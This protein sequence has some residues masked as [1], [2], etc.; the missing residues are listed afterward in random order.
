MV[1]EIY[2][3]GD[4]N[5]LAAIMNAIAAL[6]GNGTY[7]S[8]MSLSVL[9]GVLIIAFQAVNNGGGRFDIQVFVLSIVLYQVI[10]LPKA[11]VM[12]YDTYTG[13]ARQVDNVPFG[14]AWI[15]STLNTVSYGI[16]RRMELAFSTPQMTTNGFAG[17]LST[18]LNAQRIDG[19]GIADYGCTASPA[20]TTNYVALNQQDRSCSISQSVSNYIGDCVV[21]AI[22]RGDRT[23]ADIYRAERV[24]DALR[25]DY[26]ERKTTLRI[27]G[28]QPMPPSGWEYTCKDAYDILKGRLETSQFNNSFNEFLKGRFGEQDPTAAL[29][30]AMTALSNAAYNAQDFALN[31]ALRD[32]VANGM[33][34][35]ANQ[36]DAMMAAAM[37]GPGAAQRNVQWSAEATLFSKLIRPLITFFEGMMYATAPFVAFLLGL[38]TFGLKVALKYLYLPIWVSLWMP[39]MAICNLY[40]NMIAQGRMAAFEV[41]AAGSYTSMA[42]SVVM[43]SS[44]TDWLGTASMLASSVPALTMSLLFGGAVAMSSL[45]GRLQSGDYTNEKLA[46]PDVASPAAALSVQSAMTASPSTGTNKTGIEGSLPSINTAAVTQ[47]GQA[48]LSS[49]EQGNERRL[50]NAYNTVASE[51]MKTSGSLASIG[52]VDRNAAGQR[53]EKLSETQAAMTERF[54]AAG[55]DLKQAQIATNAASIS[56]GAT[57]SGGGSS[58]ASGMLKSLIGTLGLGGTSNDQKR[59]DFTKAFQDSQKIASSTKYDDST[60]GSYLERYAAGLSNRDTQQALREAGVTSGQQLS[61]AGTRSITERQQFTDT[62]A[63]TQAFTA[64]SGATPLATAKLLSSREGQTAIDNALRTPGFGGQLNAEMQRQK[65]IIG[66]N[67]SADPSVSKAMAATR[68]LVAMATAGGETGQFA[69]TQLGKLGEAIGMTTPSKQQE[70]TAN[71]DTLS[72][73]LNNAP[74]PSDAGGA[75]VTGAKAA[76]SGREAGLV[77]NRTA[78][79]VNPSNLDPDTRRQGNQAVS[80]I[81][82]DSPRQFADQAMAE[83]RAAGLRANSGARTDLADE[84]LGRI[85]SGQYNPSGS[86]VAGIQRELSD[87]A[88]VA[89]SGWGGLIGMAKSAIGSPEGQAQMAQLSTRLEDGINKAQENLEQL[90]IPPSTARE[91]AVST[92]VSGISNALS[93]AS[94]AASY[95]LEAAVKFFEGDTSSAADAMRQASG[96]SALSYSNS[97]RVGEAFTE[98]A[99]RSYGLDRDSEQDAP[100]IKAI[101]QAGAA[102]QNGFDRGDFEKGQNAAAF[103]DIA[104]MFSA[105]DNQYS[106]SSP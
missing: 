35:Y 73:D 49:I 77:A 30:Q 80:P 96:A 21:R 91:I 26:T 53:D 51:A 89:Q 1:Y 42:G 76:Q 87:L 95:Q 48:Q 67:A 8:L 10:F 18:M 98:D 88:S 13:S 36:N 69:M 104:T 59:E 61:D 71:P 25:T 15:G 70:M 43:F 3:L 90:G 68:A 103:S 105:L 85:T 44:L 45:A 31:M 9:M 32:A 20:P 99:I 72:W 6:G 84:A 83:A 92:A 41:G 102:V 78:P 16:T 27:G 4:A 11:S 93:S 60:G 100:K 37:I 33:T 2:S 5:Y 57:G 34:V 54:M 46:A 75:S 23:A 97:T 17:A 19:L 63:N 12:I 52:S 106:P 47:A 24:I 79:D 39:V 40:V 94:G 58:S 66:P 65:E 38:G 28:A 74:N 14:L 62:L 64:Q 55:L 101:E 86:G 56:A 82:G 29:G 50:S 81:S 7:S 22:G